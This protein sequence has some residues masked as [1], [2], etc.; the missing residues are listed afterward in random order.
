MK[1]KMTGCAV[2]VI[3]SCSASAGTGVQ[4]FLDSL[5]NFES[6]INPALADFYLENLNNPVY[7]YAKVSAPGRMVRDC[8]TGSMIPEDTTINQ[9]FTKLGIDG[10]YNS[11][12]PYS[13][14]MFKTMQYNS[15]NA[16]GFVG[17][18]LG[19]AVLIDAGYY[20]PKVVTV[21]GKEYDSFYVFVEDS[22]WIGC[23]TEALVEIVG[24]GGN[25]I[26]ATDVNRWEGTFVGKNGVNSFADLLIPDNQELV[27]R[28]AMRFNY[29]VMTQ[30][31]TD[32][33]MTWE[34]A[35]AK[36]WPGTDDNGNAIT[37]QATMSGLLAAAHLRGAWGT[38][39]LLT[40]DEITC[41]EL[42]TC[43]TKYV[44][45]FG[46]YN[47]IFDTPADDVIEGSKYDEKLSAGWGNDLVLPGGGADTIELHEQSGSMTTVRD[48]TVGEDRIILRDWQ[49][50]APLSNLS[51]SDVPTGVELAF[52][53]QRVVL[54][55]V[56]AAAVNVNTE[57]VIAQSDI[58]EIAWSGKQTVTG[59]NPQ[60]DKIRGTAGI[61]FK[62]LK[63]YETDTALVVGVQ[64]KDGGIYSSVEL[65]GLT[66]ADLTPEMFDNVTGGYDR[67]GFIVP[68][69]SQNWGWNM[70]LTVNSFDPAKTVISM[71]LF[72]YT[73]SMLVLTQEGADTVITLDETASKGDQKRLVLK[74]TDVNSLSAA[75]FDY[76]SGNF[77]D[78][79]IDV[80]VFYDITATVVGT[81]GSISPAPD[82]SGVI[83][84]KGN[85]DFTLTF[86]PDSGYRVATLKVDGVSVTAQSSYT[87][88]A[89]SAAHSVQVTFEPGNSCPAP[90][91]ETQVYT[92]GDQVTF[93]GKTY[94]AK[95][96]TQ[97]NNPASLG[98][99]KEIA[100]CQ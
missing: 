99:W 8:S 24:S 71:P 60:L 55:G 51:V 97:G 42:G 13:A 52:A 18:Q 32:A 70:A 76:V 57:A 39:R 21:D 40:K 78:A 81:G 34:Q 44:H 10:I 12:T 61:G 96:W 69:N 83:S 46:G 7:K 36:S 14:E 92:G 88:P 74:N 80:P 85:T 47:T 49:A 22:T 100:N 38:A 20:S 37:V 29:G 23:K 50:A 56:S 89:L 9:F 91:N 6:G 16:W 77:V 28:D 75:N 58:Y 87:F 11:Q 86:V 5:R 73:F 53:G 26:Q 62:H 90:W 15:M 72:N 4:D 1:L 27:M 17:Y 79:V 93:G 48:F 2:A 98:P 65:V 84:G 68:L 64:A 30:L 45:K 95:W 59:F 82:A 43:I 67:L 19:E 94:E 33:N 63:A 66:V 35:L 54:E 31:L 25:Q 3:L 41:D